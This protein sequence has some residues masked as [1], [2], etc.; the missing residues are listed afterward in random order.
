MEATRGFKKLTWITKNK[1]QKK[2]LIQRHKTSSKMV[3]S[4]LKLK[5]SRV[6]MQSHLLM[7][8]CFHLLSLSICL[9]VCVSQQHMILSCLLQQEIT[10]QYIL[11]YKTTYTSHLFSSLLQNVYSA[12]IRAGLIHSSNRTVRAHKTRSPIVHDDSCID[13]SPANT[14]NNK[15]LA[16]Q[17]VKIQLHNIRPTLLCTKHASHAQ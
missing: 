16:L 5:G 2:N 13:R 9:C 3:K 6:K 4:V 12:E 11:K 10:K 17:H 15:V 7:W 14:V 1:H 8:Y